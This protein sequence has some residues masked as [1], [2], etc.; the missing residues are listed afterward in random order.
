MMKPACGEK[1]EAPA[2]SIPAGGSPDLWSSSNS[3]E[4]RECEGL[5]DMWNGAG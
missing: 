3:T 1:I 2:L 4:E 5:N